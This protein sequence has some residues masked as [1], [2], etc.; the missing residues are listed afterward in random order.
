MI[1]I[2]IVRDNP[3]QVKEKARQKGY[4]ID[5]DALVHLDA[6]RRQAMGY[7][8]E[9]RAKRNGPNRSNEGQKAHSSAT[10]AG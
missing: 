6:E 1:D 7:I 10:D 2:Q 4:T 9:L 5:T 8:E 3:D